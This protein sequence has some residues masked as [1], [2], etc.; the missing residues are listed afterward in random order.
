[1]ASAGS[2][3]NVF[4]DKA[5]FDKLQTLLHEAIAGFSEYRQGNLTYGEVMYVMECTLDELRTRSEQDAKTR[6]SIKGLREAPSFGL[7]MSI[8]GRMVET[9]A[10]KGIISSGEEAYI[11]HGSE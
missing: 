10:K 3:K 11:L 4:D 2:Y 5:E 9:M 8:T 1:M 6:F 7:L